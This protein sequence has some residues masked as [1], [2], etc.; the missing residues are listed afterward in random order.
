MKMVP[1]LGFRSVLK[2]FADADWQAMKLVVERVK[3]RVT[4]EIQAKAVYPWMGLRL[5]SL[6]R[7]DY[8][9]SSRATLGKEETW[10][11]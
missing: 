3:F 2:A 11:K 9:L 10:E 4:D 6:E 8:V 1:C 5:G 7:E